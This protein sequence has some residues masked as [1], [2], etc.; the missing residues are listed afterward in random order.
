MSALDTVMNMAKSI[1]GQ[2][3][4]SLY[5]NDFEWY[6]VALELAD[7]DDNTI[8]YA[9]FYLKDGTYSNEYQEVNGWSNSIVDSF[10]FASGN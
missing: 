9:G 5:P 10:L 2:A 8:D 1:G 6:M 3:L 7:S 4:A